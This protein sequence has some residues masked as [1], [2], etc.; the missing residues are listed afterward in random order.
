MD[1]LEL[2]IGRRIKWVA[3]RIKT[4]ADLQPRH[5]GRVVTFTVFYNDDPTDYNTYDVIGTLEGRSDDILLVSGIEY[6]WH[7][8]A[9]VKIHRSELV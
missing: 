4:L 1:T 2:L 9:D 8:V 7:R 6:Q 3:D 5:I